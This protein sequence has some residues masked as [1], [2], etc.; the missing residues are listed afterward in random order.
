MV[1]I[2]A[3]EPAM[4]TSKE[5]IETAR[6]ILE[7]NLEWISAAESKVGFVVAIVTAMI[8]GLAAAYSD[9]DKV[10]TLG[11]GTSAGAVFLCMLS[12]VSAA[13]CVRSRT[14]GPPLSLVFF[15]RIVEMNSREYVERLSTATEDELLEDLARQ[16]HRNAQ[17]AKEKHAWASTAMNLAFW[18][19]PFWA[20]AIASLI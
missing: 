4:S 20:L 19:A 8:A 16:I 9:A 18:A 7:R 2:V 12:I 3:G 10:S 14:D 13:S 15:S 11:A 5:R 17:I 1:A 6:W